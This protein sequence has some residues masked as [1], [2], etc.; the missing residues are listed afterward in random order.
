[1]QKV[2]HNDLQSEVRNILIRNGASPRFQLEIIEFKSQKAYLTINEN[3]T[4][5]V[6]DDQK[7]TLLDILTSAQVGLKPGITTQVRLLRRGKKYLMPLHSIF[8]ED[9]PDIIVYDKDHIFVEDRSTNIISSV[10]KV[11]H[12]GEVVFTGIGRVK[13][14]NRTLNDLRAQISSQIDEIPGSKNAFQIEITEF[15]RKLLL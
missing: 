14:V 5:Q 4:I 13:A 2:R 8:D 6:L 10:S 12:N 7:I 1:M 3:S 15:S 9:A 11:G